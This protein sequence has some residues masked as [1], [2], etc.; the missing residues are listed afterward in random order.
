MQLKKKRIVILVCL[1][2]VLLLSAMLIIDSR[3]GDNKQRLLVEGRGVAITVER[4]RSFKENVELV[5]AVS[6]TK[7]PSEKEILDELT[8]TELAVAYA[9]DKGLTAA[10]E[11]ID[12]VIDA[13][14]SALAEAD[15][16]HGPVIELMKQRIGK[17]G[18]TEEEFWSSEETRANYERSVLLG[19]L[20]VILID[21]GTIK[22]YREF[23]DFQRKLL[24]KYRDS[25]YIDLSLLQ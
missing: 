22:D 17:T 12:E 1:A 23:G 9:R 14:R 24:E 5:A 18:L 19:E 8:A 20:A 15:P 4:F 7:V 16:D 6:D 3:S 21:E 10:R 2:A 25:I 11:E 13:E